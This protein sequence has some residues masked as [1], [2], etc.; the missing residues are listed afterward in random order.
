MLQD[1]ASFMLFWQFCQAK[2]SAALFLG[3]GCNQQKSDL[4][5]MHFVPHASCVRYYL[6]SLIPLLIRIDILSLQHLFK[7]FREL[8]IG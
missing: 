8:A 4:E 1:S 3:Q 6:V 2:S 5:W 7:P